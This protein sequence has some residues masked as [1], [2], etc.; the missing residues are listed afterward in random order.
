MKTSAFSVHISAEDRRGTA[1]A[2]MALLERTISLV[3]NSIYLVPLI[4]LLLFFIRPRGQSK[5]ARVGGSPR[6]LLVSRTTHRWLNHG[7][8]ILE[9]GYHQV[10]D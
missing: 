10:S 7:L 1:I 5:I 9:H 8:E 6:S 3:D 2:I 4:A